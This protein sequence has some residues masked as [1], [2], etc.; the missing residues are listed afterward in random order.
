MD[1]GTKKK[2]RR[3]EKTNSSSGVVQYNL[4][5]MSCCQ[6]YAQYNLDNLTPFWH[7]ITCQI[8]D[9]LDILC[10]ESFFSVILQG[11]CSLA[12]WMVVVPLCC[13]SKCSYIG[14]YTLTFTL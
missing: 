1:E 14:L 8:T 4:T 7:L 6:V 12:C 5:L 11:F 2:N 9:Y 3:R 10:D 13:L